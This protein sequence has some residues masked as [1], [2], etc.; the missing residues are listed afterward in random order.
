MMISYGY[1]KN[2]SKSREEKSI[3]RELAHE[4]IN[5]Q[6]IDCI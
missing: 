4:S 2:Q 6:E 1:F 3:T 5:F